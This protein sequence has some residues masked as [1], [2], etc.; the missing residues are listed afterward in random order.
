MVIIKTHQE[1]GNKW[2]KIAKRSPGMTDNA[3]TDH[4]NV[5]KRRQRFTIKKK[6][7]TIED[8]E[9]SLLHAYIRKVLVVKESTKMLKNNTSE[10]NMN[11]S[12]GGCETQTIVRLLNSTPMVLWEIDREP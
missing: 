5:T 10:K 12:S 6:S 4:W 3:V 9:G 11:M 2:E 7:K 8:N 1:V